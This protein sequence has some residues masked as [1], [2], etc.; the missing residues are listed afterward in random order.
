MVVIYEL[1]CTNEYIIDDLVEL[2]V[3]YDCPNHFITDEWS[4]L[5]CLFRRDDDFFLFSF[6]IVQLKERMKVCYEK[7]WKSSKIHVAI[8]TMHIYWHRSRANLSDIDHFFFSCVPFAC[9][10][11]I[12]WS[13][14]YSFFFYHYVN[15]ATGFGV[16]FNLDIWMIDLITCLIPCHWSVFWWFFFSSTKQ[17]KTRSYL[18]KNASNN[19]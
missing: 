3:P 9:C 8:L 4:S 18:W 7:S 11:A 6:A 2:N 5:E 15:E 1:C 13:H 14:A 19:S 16:S 12:G 10:I 17:M